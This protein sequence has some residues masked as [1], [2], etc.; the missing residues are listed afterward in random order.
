MSRFK[1]THERIFVYSLSVKNSIYI[2]IHSFF[3]IDKLQ[4][5][6]WGSYYL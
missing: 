3:F 1:F 2:S 5:D 6:E 4:K